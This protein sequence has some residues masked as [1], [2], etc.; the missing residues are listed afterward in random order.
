MST[1]SL[2]TG[3]V[4]ATEYRKGVV[5]QINVSNGGSGYTVAPTITFSGGNPEAGA[6]AAAAT[7]TIANGSVIYR[8]VIDFNNL[9]VVKDTPPLLL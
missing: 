3:R 6:V 8:N 4:Q 5:Y 1:G 2:T 7:C 9:K